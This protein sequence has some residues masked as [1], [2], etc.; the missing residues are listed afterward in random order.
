[1][2]F[3]R[4]ENALKLL[5]SEFSRRVKEVIIFDE[6]EKAFWNFYMI[7]LLNIFYYYQLNDLFY[8]TD[9]D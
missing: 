1:M 3:T 8:F 6:F 2:P 9:C 7:K 4:D 5:Q